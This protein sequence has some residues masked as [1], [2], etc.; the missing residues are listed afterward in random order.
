MNPFKIN[1]NELDREWLRQ[2]ELMHDYSVRLAEARRGADDATNGVVVVRADLD[3][4]IRTDPE[5]YGLA[6]ATEAG[7]ENTIPQQPEYIAALRAVVEARHA[8]RILE[9]ACTA[10]EHKKRALENCVKLWQNDYFS[11]PRAEVVGKATEAEKT[12]ARR[13]GVRRTAKKSEE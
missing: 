10:L 9:A 3:G 6:K 5:T 11:A 13:R 4:Q 2:P 12:A 7:I 1:E 8:V